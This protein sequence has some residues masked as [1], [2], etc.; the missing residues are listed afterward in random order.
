[1]SLLQIAA[2]VVIGLVLATI[3]ICVILIVVYSFEHRGDN[4]SE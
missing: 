1:M 2:L 4:G 3:V